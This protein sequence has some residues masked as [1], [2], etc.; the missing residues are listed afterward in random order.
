MHVSD[1]LPVS[2][3]ATPTL[4]EWIPVPELPY[5]TKRRGAN[6]RFTT[7]TDHLPEYR[8]RQINT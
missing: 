6:L 1:R 4:W 3:V 5:M 7:R 8:K 2:D